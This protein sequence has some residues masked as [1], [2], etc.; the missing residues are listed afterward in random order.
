M[1]ARRT[2]LRSVALVGAGCLAASAL[3]AASGPPTALP[4]ADAPGAWGPVRPLGTG[5]DPSCGG[6]ARTTTTDGHAVARRHVRDRH[7]LRA[8]Q[9]RRRDVGQPSP[10]QRLDGSLRPGSHRGGRPA[11]LRGLAAPRREGLGAVPAA[12]H[13]RRARGRV[14]A[15]H[16]H[17]A[18]HRAGRTRVDRCGGVDGVR[19]H[20]ADAH[21]QG[22]GRHRPQ[23]RPV[24]VHPR[25]GHG[26]TRSQPHRCG[27]GGVRLRSARRRRVGAR[28]ADQGAHLARRRPQVGPGHRARFRR[29]SVRARARLARRGGSRD[30]RPHRVG[31]GAQRRRMGCGP[32]RPRG[33]DAREGRPAGRAPRHRGGR[34]RGEPSRGRRGRRGQHPDV[35][36]V[37]RRRSDVGRSDAG[38]RADHLLRDAV[39]RPVALDRRPLRRLAAVGGAVLRA[40][41]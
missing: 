14:E 38:E 19:R 24:L 13:R 31:T 40:R 21:R 34:R 26:G 8:Q 35:A 3:L 9:Q 28:P 39:Q 32:S 37:A 16:P 17:H 18:G 12:Q 15:A 36:A 4:T 6:L 30:A 11:R 29:S 33:R 7:G 22:R 2:S 5:S 41:T 20:H 25:A 23:A 1:H 10:R 27:P